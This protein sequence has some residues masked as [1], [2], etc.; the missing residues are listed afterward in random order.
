MLLLLMEPM[1]VKIFA[2]E[3]VTIKQVGY[4]EDLSIGSPY[5]TMNPWDVSSYTWDLENPSDNQYVR[6]ED[7]SWSLAHAR[8]LKAT[9]SPVTVKLE[10]VMNQYGTLRT[11]NF[12]WYVTVLDTSPT[13]IFISPSTPQRLAINSSM[14]FSYTLR[15][16]YATTTVT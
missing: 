1:S 12:F 15:P 6:I 2:V 10:L 4:V 7:K 14:P 3:S 13:G 16:S 11:Y 8:G 9:P 5:N